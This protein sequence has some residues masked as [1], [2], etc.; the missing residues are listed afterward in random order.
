MYSFVHSIF[1]YYL[2]LF[3]GRRPPPPP[4]PSFNSTV[5]LYHIQ[6]ELCL[7]CRPRGRWTWL[8]V[9]SSKIDYYFQQLQH[10]SDEWVQYNQTEPS[11]LRL[12]ISGYLSA[13]S[14]FLYPFYLSPRTQSLPAP[15]EEWYICTLECVWM[16]WKIGRRWRVY[17]TYMYRPVYQGWR[18]HLLSHV[19][20]F[21]YLFI[22]GFFFFEDCGL[23][24]CVCVRTC[25][26]SHLLH[27]AHSI[28]GREA[29]SDTSKVAQRDFGFV[30]RDFA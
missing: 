26:P 29:A 27:N 14:W 24:A 13:L 7:I 5:P 15:E 4:P 11:G 22:H 16:W 6:Y 28:K 9:D 12:S 8:V 21:I 1:L 2:H 19:Y 30:Q 20:L 18:V 25:D 17:S 10:T 3:P 23:F